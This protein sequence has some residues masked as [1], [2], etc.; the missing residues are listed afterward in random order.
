LSASG[1]ADGLPGAP[2]ILGAVAELEVTVV[3][4]TRNRWRL[5]ST[6]ALPSALGQE[7]VDHEVVVVD[8]GSTDETSERLRAL[9][10]PR[11]RVVRHETALGVA[12]ARNAGIAAACGEWVAFL[13]DDDLWS[14]LKLRRQVDAAQR[15]AAFVYTAAAWLDERRRFLYGLRPADPRGL[16]RE[17]LRWNVIWAGCSNVAA[18]TELVRQVGGFDERLFQLADWDLWIRLAL[19][20]EAAAEPE[21]LVGYVMQPESMLLTD[22]RPVFREFDYFLAKHRA[23]AERLGAGLDRARFARWVARGHLRAG[24]RLRAARTYAGGAVRYRDPVSFGRAAASLLGERGLA[25]VRALAG[26]VR[27][28]DSAWRLDGVEPEW[29]ARYR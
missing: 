16:A 11:L 27:E 9:G 3:V 15:G 26:P 4:P 7:Q 2:R 24:R 29:I 17:L 5:L 1:G 13:D 28:D 6:A 20:G 10:D 21:L 19:A 23:A 12:H 8:D 25:R 18:R 22:R 14:P